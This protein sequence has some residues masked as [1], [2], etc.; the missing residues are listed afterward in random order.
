MTRLDQLLVD[1]GKAL[2]LKEASALIMTGTV[3]VDDNV[4][5]KPGTGVS[6]GS[7]VRIKSRIPYVSRGGLKLEGALKH[8]KISPAGWICADI[9]AS[10][11]GFTDCLLQADAKC[12]YAVDV[13]YGILDWKLR[14]DSRVIVIERCN[15]RKLN[16]DA[17]D[18]AIDFAVFDTSF[19]SLTKVIPPVL[20]LFRTRQIR[21][22]ALVKPQFECVKEKISDGGIIVNE[23]DRLEAVQRIRN[24]GDELGLIC[25]GVT[26]SPITGAKGNQEYLIYWEGTVGKT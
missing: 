22:V 6:P 9:G 19:I 20:P 23:E 26:Q 5:D 10:T 1:R 15:V 13:A 17:I 25:K 3:L 11:G 8:F 4:V 16:E 24:F 14:S 2:N 21:I 12:V 18:Q 7:I